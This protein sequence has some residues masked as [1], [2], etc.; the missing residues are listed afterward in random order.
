MSNSS[1][2]SFVRLTIT[3]LLLVLGGFTVAA[4]NAPANPAVKAAEVVF[5]SG[6]P[7]IVGTST[8]LKTG[9]AVF[10]GQA[11]VT[12][13]ADHLYLKTVDDGFISLRPHSEARIVTYRY[14][15][16]A[17]HTSRIKLELLRGV[18]RSIS[19]QGGQQAREQYRVN[20]PVA[21]IGLRGTDFTVFVDHD[22]TRVTVRS[23]GI[24]M[25]PFGAQCDPAGRGPCAGSNAATLMA[26]QA[27]QMLELHRGDTHPSLVKTGPRPDDT[28][29][30]L[31]QEKTTAPDKASSN[32]LPQQA[33][34]TLRDQALSD[35]AEAALAISVTPV[36]H[37][38][39]WNKLAEHPA[40]FDVIALAAAGAIP[41]VI[42]GTHIIMQNRSDRE[43]LALPH[44]G[45]A[46]FVLASGESFITNAAR[47]VAIPATIRNAQLTID[48]GSSRFD[49]RLDLA[50]NAETFALITNGTINRS[51]GSMISYPLGINGS[52]AYVEGILGQGGT[53]AGYLFRQPVSGGREA[54]GATHWV[55]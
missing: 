6:Q 15:P 24:V 26:D 36:V 3:T 14:D 37:W 17:P 45:R 2:S 28:T 55:R 31:P 47:T 39:R 9:D 21:A 20:T 12:G 54:I 1:N 50:A 23:G 42:N 22:T 13:V 8:P 49:T 11:L 35:R 25:S 40:N 51:D 53:Q 27:R 4:D 10:E 33:I 38:G 46:G 18:V 34:G 48:F 29:P 19:G 16:A 30:P 52:N 5:V 41:R 32:S 7:R 44:S 43:M